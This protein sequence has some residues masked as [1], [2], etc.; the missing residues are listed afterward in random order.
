MCVPPSKTRFDSPSASKRRGQHGLEHQG[1]AA[2]RA[3]AEG[4]VARPDRAGAKHQS[5]GAQGRPFHFGAADLGRGQHGRQVLPQQARLLPPGAD[6][7]DHEGPARHQGKGQR[8][9]EHLPAALALGA[10]DRE[11]PG[12]HGSDLARVPRQISS[13]VT[14]GR[15]GSRD[16]RVAERPEYR[17]SPRRTQPWG[18]PSA[19]PPDAGLDRL[20]GRFGRPPDRIPSVDYCV[21][22]QKYPVFPAK[23]P[24]SRNHLQNR[25][26]RGKLPL[27]IDLGLKTP[28]G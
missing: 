28:V 23:K 10:V 21:Y 16:R 4:V 25:K 11:H 6:L 7:L 13:I 18:R 27:S 19:G 14:P 1:R 17:P 26:P 9:A 2:G 15:A 12:P 20:P 24:G 5:P 22:A 3:D 8:R